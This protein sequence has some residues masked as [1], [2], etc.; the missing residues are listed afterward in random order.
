MGR[1]CFA[2]IQDI[3][4]RG[5]S[6]HGEVCVGSGAGGDNVGKTTSQ[7]KHLSRTVRRGTWPKPTW[8]ITTAKSDRLFST[9]ETRATSS[10]PLSNPT[11][12]PQVRTLRGRSNIADERLYLYN[13]KG[14]ITRQKAPPPPG[15]DAYLY[16]LSLCSYFYVPSPKTF[17]T[18]GMTSPDWTFR[19]YCFCTYWE[20]NP[21]FLSSFS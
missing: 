1:E 4:H 6:Y 3:G 14:G 18:E 2:I 7:A 10:W 16:V 17:S 21:F 11:W 19:V 13:V 20:L 15:R 12:E 5:M 9:L 8:Q